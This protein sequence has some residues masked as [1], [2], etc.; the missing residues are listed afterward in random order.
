MIL[1]GYIID[2]VDSELS[3]FKENISRI[4]SGNMIISALEIKYCWDIKG[5]NIEIHI[6]SLT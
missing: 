1:S 2:S 4:E 6:S 5:N 3:N